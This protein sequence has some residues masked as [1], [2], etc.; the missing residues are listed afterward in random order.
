MEYHGGGTVLPREIYLLHEPDV[1]THFQNTVQR[2]AEPGLLSIQGHII[3]KQ[4]CFIAGS[5]KIYLDSVLFPLLPFGKAK[6]HV[7][8]ALK[9]TLTAFAGTKR[10]GEATSS[11]SRFGFQLRLS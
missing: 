3:S 2:R 7:V 11:L 5:S 9:Y 6:L 1:P 10:K 4:T 8:G